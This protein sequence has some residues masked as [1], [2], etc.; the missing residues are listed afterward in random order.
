MGL[1]GNVCYRY[2]K[3]PYTRVSCVQA[4]DYITGVPTPKIQHFEG[5]SKLGEYDTMVSLVPLHKSTV[6]SNALEAMRV[7]ANKHLEPL[8]LTNFYFL[9]PHYPHQVLREN[10]MATGAGADR[11]QE[12]MRQA[13]GRPIGT[14]AQIF[15]GSPLIKVKTYKKFVPAVKSALDKAHHKIYPK[16]RIMIEPILEKITEQ[17]PQPAKAA[18][19]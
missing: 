2:I 3:R 12:G 18:A 11:F 7:T 9:I 8:G 15:A 16:C 4:K 19:A 10:K 13:Y 1:R 17:I 6:R 14:A 5:G